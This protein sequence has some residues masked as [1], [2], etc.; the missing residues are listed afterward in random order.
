[1]CESRVRLMIFFFGG[2]YVSELDRGQMDETCFETGGL[3]SC[4][5]MQELLHL[6]MCAHRRTGKTARIVSPVL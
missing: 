2:V 4:Q 6:L 5:E 1:M 3:W